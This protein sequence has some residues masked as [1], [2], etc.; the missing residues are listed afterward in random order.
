[1]LSTKLI[2][3]W[4]TSKIAL[5]FRYKEVSVFVDVTDCGVAYLFINNIITVKF[6]EIK[7]KV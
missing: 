4:P 6:L 7:D 5:P 1:M 2:T 3:T